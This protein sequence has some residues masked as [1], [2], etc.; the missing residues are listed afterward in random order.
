MTPEELDNRLRA[1]NPLV[2]ALLKEARDTMAAVERER[3][4]CAALV[5]SV[6]AQAAEAIRA[7]GR[8]WPWTAYPPQH[9]EKR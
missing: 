8:R 6:S 5:E 9:R 3:E 1:E 7:R 4:A 2:L